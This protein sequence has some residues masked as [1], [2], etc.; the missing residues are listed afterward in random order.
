MCVCVCERERERERERQR[1][2]ESVYMCVFWKCQRVSLKS[3]STNQSM[4]VK[5]PPMIGK[6][7]L[8]EAERLIPRTHTI[9]IPIIQ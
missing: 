1:Q 6:E 4:H 5:K 9:Y 7:L 3:L 8:K 2:R